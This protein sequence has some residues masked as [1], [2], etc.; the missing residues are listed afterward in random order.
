MSVPSLSAGDVGQGTLSQSTIVTLFWEAGVSTWFAYFSGELRQ[1]DQSFVDEYLNSADMPSEAD[2]SASARNGRL[3]CMQVVND[4][5]E[6]V[7]GVVPSTVS[8]ADSSG[9]I[10]H[11]GGKPAN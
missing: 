11:Y 5:L 7:S 10:S 1:C 6:T 2:L 4:E 9:N 8:Q 3:Y